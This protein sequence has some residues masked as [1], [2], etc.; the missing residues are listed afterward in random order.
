MRKNACDK[1]KHVRQS[2]VTDVRNSSQSELQ[3]VCYLHDERQSQSNGGYIA[4]IRLAL[5]LI[6]WIIEY[7]YTYTGTDTGHSVRGSAHHNQVLL[8]LLYISPPEPS[9]LEITHKY[10]SR[11][12]I[13]MW[14]AY[15]SPELRDVCYVTFHQYEESAAQFRCYTHYV[16]HRYEIRNSSPFDVG[17]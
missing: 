5:K 3:P 10:Y 1:T 15:P 14:G 6:R 16:C 7:E 17:K 4:A 12:S 8:K 11:F 13:S 9:T 2:R